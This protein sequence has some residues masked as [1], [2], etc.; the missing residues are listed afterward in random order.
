VLQ[1]LLEVQWEFIC[2]Q[3]LHVVVSSIAKLPNDAFV[4]AATADTRFMVNLV[5]LFMK[6]HLLALLQD[7]CFV[8]LFFPLK[9]YFHDKFLIMKSTTA[10]L[11]KC[12]CIVWTLF[13]AISLA[14]LF[15]NSFLHHGA[16]SK[17]LYSSV[18]RVDYASTTFLTIC[19]NCSKNTVVQLIIS[20]NFTTS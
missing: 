2:T 8:G 12:F 20:M 14:L 1:K 16:R 5:L 3:H 6:L 19:R 4:V 7:N 15:C 9:L 11:R 13:H 17:Q 18:L 10:S